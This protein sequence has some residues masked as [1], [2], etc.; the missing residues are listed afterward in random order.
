[1]VDEKGWL[2]NYGANDGAL[3]FKLNSGHYRDYR[4]QLQALAFTAGMDIGL[5]SEDAGWYGLERQNANEWRPADGIHSFDKGGYYLIREPETFTF[6]K[7]GSYKDRPSQ[8]D[9]LH[10][11]I[12][13]KG[14]NILLDAGTYKYNTDAQTMR[15]FSGTQSHNTVMLDNSDQML[16]G[17]HFL[18]FYWSQSIEAGLKEEGDSFVFSGE[19]NA[20]K[21]IKDD[22]VHR[23]T[24]VKRKGVAVWEVKD[25]IIG[26]PGGMA[27]Q[28]LWHVSLGAAGVVIRKV[29]TDGA[30]QE[31]Q[32]RD[33]WSSSLYG[34]REKTK[35]YYFSTTNNIIYTTIKVDAGK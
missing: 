6:I 4:G 15:Y 3:F 20:F 17:G 18:W 28:Q 21:Y 29:N 11:D 23:R 12:W 14:E 24:V 16:K 7:C 27:L 19:V 26:A 22:I 30:E 8:A 34:E 25:E 32:L 2:P 33:G 10:I 9:N 5:E 1:M 35:E 31:P 13:V